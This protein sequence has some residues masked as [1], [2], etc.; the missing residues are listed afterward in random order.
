VDA[1]GACT[2]RDGQAGFDSNC[3]RATTIDGLSLIGIIGGG[4]LVIIGSS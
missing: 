2:W 3:G 4:V 1:T